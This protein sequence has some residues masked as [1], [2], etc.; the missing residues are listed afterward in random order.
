MWGIAL[1]LPVTSA[2][3]PL[4]RGERLRKKGKER[5]EME[6]D[7][8][9]YLCRNTEKSISH[10]FQVKRDDVLGHTVQTKRR[11]FCLIAVSVQA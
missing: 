1:L 8:L 11:A 9:I 5:K 3:Q 4:F 6:K 2:C 10:H 7:Q